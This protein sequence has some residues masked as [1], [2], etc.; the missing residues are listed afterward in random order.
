MLLE[1]Q[2]KRALRRKN[3]ETKIKKRV[4][5][6][7]EIWKSFP[8]KFIPGRYHKWNLCCTC[9]MCSQAKQNKR[10][11]RKFR[12]TNKKIIKEYFLTED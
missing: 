2:K 6:L 7:K 12:R 4:R 1:K 10:E 9:W 5:I 11:N 3:R 8:G